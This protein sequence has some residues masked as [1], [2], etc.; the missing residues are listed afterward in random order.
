MLSQIVEVLFLV[1]FA[2]TLAS[3][4]IPTL[5]SKYFEVPNISEP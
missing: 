3:G 2:Q 5:W 1:L 4:A